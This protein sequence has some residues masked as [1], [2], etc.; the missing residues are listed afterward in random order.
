MAFK[1]STL[2]AFDI[3]NL[4]NES[5]TPGSQ[6]VLYDGA[7]PESVDTPAT[8]QNE[9]A[10]FDLP[11]PLFADPEET[12][13][14]VLLTANAIEP[15]EAVETGTASWFRVYAAD[16]VP[17]IQGVVTNMAGT[18]EIKLPTTA[19]VAGISIEIMSISIR[20]RSA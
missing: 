15:V 7:V 17:L 6:L 4:I 9:L 14:G 20:A 19:V 12:E 11:S 16:E 1:I 13:G 5:I 3:A 2:L 18:G 8:D 10:I